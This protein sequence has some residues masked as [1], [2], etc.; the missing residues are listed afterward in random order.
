[1]LNTVATNKIEDANGKSLPSVTVSIGL[2]QLGTDDTPLR[3]LQNADQALY[4][5][6]RDG[7][8]RVAV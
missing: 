5:A 8:N 1:V 4:R 7:R 2:A 3:M 6:K